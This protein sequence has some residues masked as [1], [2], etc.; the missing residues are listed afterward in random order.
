MKIENSD[1]SLTSRNTSANINFVQEKLNFWVGKKPESKNSNTNS[2]KQ[3]TQNQNTQTPIIQTPIAQNQNIQN[4]LIQKLNI[5]DQFVQTQNTQ[6][7]NYLNIS[8]NIQTSVSNSNSKYEFNSDYKIELL[9]AMGRQLFGE[10]FDIKLADYSSQQQDTSQA[11]SQTQPSDQT[12][13]QSSDQ[14]QTQNETAGWGLEYDRKEVKYEHQ[15]SDFNADGVIKTADGKEIKFSLKMSLQYENY[16]ENNTSIQAGDAVK[17]DPII[18]NFD[19]NSNELSSQ[20]FD[21]DLESN[22]KS[23][24]IPYLKSGSGFLVLDSNSDGKINNGKELFGPQTGDGFQE[25]S[26]LD[27]DKNGWIDESDS[28]YSQL[29]VWEKTAD[30][31][32]KIS[33]LSQKNIDAL[34]LGKANTTFNYKDDTGNNNAE[35]VSTGLYVKNNQQVGLMKQVDILV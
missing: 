9:K 29:G 3:I 26:Q 17:K 30:G 33:S 16:Q 25:L 18:I 15:T 27:S 31:T 35:L 14:T 21:F 13:A 10:D 34:Y 22:G 8:K 19:G 23:E 7:S 24:K 32:D 4:Q 2:Q 28:S 1:I 20:R 6:N 11:Q 12:Q 5:Q